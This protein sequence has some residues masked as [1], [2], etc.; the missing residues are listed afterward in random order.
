MVMN[1][2]S[3]LCISQCIFIFIFVL[4]PLSLLVEFYFITSFK[5]LFRVT[6][7]VDSSFVLYCV[8]NVHK[9]LFYNMGLRLIHHMLVLG[10]K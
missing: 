4:F 10:F 1:L 8:F 3:L 9:I 5:S 6:S 7:F 2:M